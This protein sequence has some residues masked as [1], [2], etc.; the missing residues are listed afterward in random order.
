VATTSLYA[1][2]RLTGVQKTSGTWILGGSY[3][4]NDTGI[5]FGIVSSGGYGQIQYTSG[6]EAGFVSGKMAFTAFTSST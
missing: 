4:G 1:Q 5:D 2:Y 3:I 6:N